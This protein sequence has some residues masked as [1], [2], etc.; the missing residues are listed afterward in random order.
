[1]SGPALAGSASRWIGRRVGTWAATVVTECLRTAVTLA[2]YVADAA[3]GIRSPG[4]VKSSR[5]GG[6]SYATGQY[7]ICRTM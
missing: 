2:T 6:G 5:P 3:Y 7:S 1:M 4:V